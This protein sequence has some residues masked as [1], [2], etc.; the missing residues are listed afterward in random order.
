ML[1][2][3]EDAIHKIFDTHGAAAIY[4]VST[5]YLSRAIYSLYPNQ[6]IFY[7]KGSMGLAPGIGLGLAVSCNRDIVVISGDG[8]LLMHLGLTHTIRDVGAKNLFVYIID[9]GCYESVG[10]F[11]CSDLESSYPGVTEIIKVQRA[12][13][14]T[15][16]VPLTF[17]DNFTKLKEL[18]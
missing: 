4:V 1:L 9:N 3:R 12:E 16:R 17:K 14:P 10:G 5:G 11:K 2:S 7:M 18:F 15:T 6:N 13:K 8:A